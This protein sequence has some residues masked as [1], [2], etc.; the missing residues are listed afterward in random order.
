[1]VLLL[2]FLQAADALVEHLALLQHLPFQAAEAALQV[3]V[4]RAVLGLIGAPSRSGIAGLVRFG[5]SRLIL[6]IGFG[7]ARLSVARLRWLPLAQTHPRHPGS[8]HKWSIGPI[9]VH[10]AIPQRL[11]TAVQV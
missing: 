6:W 5:I 2:L 4:R 9:D 11:R 7:I 1:V 10:R 3:G 8:G